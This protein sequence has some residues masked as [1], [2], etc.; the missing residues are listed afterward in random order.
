MGKGKNQS[1]DG[2]KTAEKWQQYGTKQE[3]KNKSGGFRRRMF[4]R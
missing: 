4:Y 3:E 1:G 2:K